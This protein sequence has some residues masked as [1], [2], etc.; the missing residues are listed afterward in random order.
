[1]EIGVTHSTEFV[2]GEVFRSYVWEGPHFG[3]LSPTARAPGA[4]SIRRPP[5]TPVEIAIDSLDGATRAEIAVEFWGGHIG[6]SEQS[7]RVNEGPWLSLPQPDGTP[8]P[9]E[10][11]YRT[12]LGNPAVEIPLENL[13]AGVNRVQFHAG[14]Q[15]CHDFQWGFFWIYAFSIRL[16]Y[17]DLP[18]N[19]HPKVAAV[20]DKAG[21]ESVDISVEATDPATIARVDCLARYR[22]HNWSGNGRFRDWHYFLRSGGLRGHAGTV[23][24]STDGG[25]PPAQPDVRLAW[26]TTNVP[27]Q[28]EPIRLMA[29]VTRADGTCTVS[30]VTDLDY[31]RIGRSLKLI[32]PDKVPESFGVRIGQGKTCLFRDVRVQG[33]KSARLLLS[34]WS[35]AHADEIG[36]NGKRITNRV[37]LVHDV[38][39]DTIDVPPGLLNDGTN[40]FYIFSRTEHHAA[41][42]N[43]PGPSLLLE[44]DQL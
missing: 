3:E 22:D 28:D 7:F 21:A 9:P 19:E 1:M 18:A 5:H 20:P 39:H 4:Q 15:I 2:P 44:Y 6:T 42:L 24:G 14:P 40:S 37:G 12:V 33:L 34:T 25:D 13:R 16:F 27:D 32:E 36:I 41:E 26:D 35:G 38:S 30:S 31:R 17:T 11:Y 10:C 8:G 29:L 43:W 23:F